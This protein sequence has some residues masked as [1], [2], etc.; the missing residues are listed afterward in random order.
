MSGKLVF[1]WFSSEE[2]NN[3]LKDYNLW[4]SQ[5]TKSVLSLL[6][7]DIDFCNASN[8]NYREDNKDIVIL[9][10][11]AISHED[12]TLYILWILEDRITLNLVS[13]NTWH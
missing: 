1:K 3:I 8:D 13:E 5:V 2:V 7:G 9:K 4:S 6:S 10:N 12:L 11:L